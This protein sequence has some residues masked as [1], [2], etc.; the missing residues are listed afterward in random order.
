MEVTAE[1]II[2]PK[3]LVEYNS[4]KKVEHKANHITCSD[5]IKI[6]I[7]KTIK[8]MLID[9]KGDGNKNIK[10]IC[11]INK[12]KAPNITLSVVVIYLYM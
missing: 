7:I 5:F 6:S 2:T 11:N 12:R 10:L 4:I 8:M 3:G 9:E 1:I